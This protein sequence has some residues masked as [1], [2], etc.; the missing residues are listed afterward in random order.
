MNHSSKEAQKMRD[1]MNLP[2]IL[3]RHTEGSSKYRAKY[4]GSWKEFWESKNPSNSFPVNQECD[5]CQKV[6]SNFVGGHVTAIQSEKTYIYPICG[7]CNDKYG[8]G[9]SNKTFQAKQGL[10]VPFNP[11]EDAYINK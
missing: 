9:K 1:S 6:A 8:V 5:C 2:L 3:V 4:F 7:E 10:L 11:T